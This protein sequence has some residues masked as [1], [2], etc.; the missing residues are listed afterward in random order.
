VRRPA[1]SL[2]ALL[3]AALL[4]ACDRSVA[5]V[6]ERPPRTV[7]V[8]GFG[9]FGPYE[10]NPAWDSV[11]DLE[12]TTVGTCRVRTKRLDV[13]YATAGAQLRAAIEAVRPDVVLC[14]GVAPDDVLRIETTARNRDTAA[15]PDNAGVVRRDLAIRDAGATTIATRLPVERIE[16][17]LDRGGFPHRRSD[18]AG[19][20]LCNHVF[21]ELMADVPPDRVAGFVHVPS[22][23]KSW[24]LDRLKKA[25]RTIL[26]TLGDA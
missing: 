12:G 15:A 19:G 24:D 1:S 7:L 13:V 9:P 23:G 10:S 11:K 14:L 5:S 6:P 3:G 17:A 22:L 16:A 25:V 2:A 26:E 8:T 4:A 20:Y 21:Y 18:D